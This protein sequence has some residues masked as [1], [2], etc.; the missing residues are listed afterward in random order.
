MFNLREGK[1]KH[2]SDGQVIAK[3]TKVRENADG[4]LGFKCEPEI[5]RV[6]LYKKVNRRIEVRRKH[7]V[8]LF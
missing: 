6:P 4:L 3:I 1:D 2:L 5:T 7:I 8:C